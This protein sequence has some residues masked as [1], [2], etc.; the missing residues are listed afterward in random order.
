M[1]RAGPFD[2]HYE[3]ANPQ[4]WN[5]LSFKPGDVGADYLEWP[6]HR[7]AFPQGDDGGPSGL[8]GR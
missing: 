1:Q 3:I 4:P 8:Q 5:R 6:V 7:Q 2:E